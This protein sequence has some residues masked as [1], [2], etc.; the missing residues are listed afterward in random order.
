MNRNRQPEG[1]PTGGQFATGSKSESDVELNTRPPLVESTRQRGEFTVF[2]ASVKDVPSN[3]P[4]FKRQ[5]IHP[6]GHPELRARG[7]LVAMRMDTDGATGKAHELAEGR[8]KA[9]VLYQYKDGS[10][11][12]KEG[13][14]V[15]YGDDLAVV[16]KG[17]SSGKGIYLRDA[18]ILAVEK[19][20][21][22]AQ[23]LADAYRDA[24]D[25]FPDVEEA[26]FD[27]IPE[28]GP[29]ER[30][31]EIAAVYAFTHPGFEPGQDGRGSLFFVTDIQRGDGIV[32]GYGVY[33]PGSGM[34]SEHGS[35][36]V[37]DLKKTGGRVAGYRPG[38]LTFAD[39]MK[40]GEQASSYSSDGDMNPAWDA[41]A[42]ASR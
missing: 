27:D 34:F 15:M 22:K 24:E 1:I 18:R 5:I 11:N 3:N 41:V 13:T 38:E 20:Y 40:L 9:T 8:E 37:D 36:Y 2:N 23:K 16:N 35:M 10:V 39:A 30:L 14:L 29:T 4:S 31:N 32:N 25:S 7:G 42:A 12:I 6:G 26:T 33:P 17:S 19:G 28:E 21:G